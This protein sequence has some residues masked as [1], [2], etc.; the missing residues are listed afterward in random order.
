MLNMDT[1]KKSYASIAALSFI[2][3]TSLPHSPHLHHV[4]LTKFRITYI[5]ACKAA[6]SDPDTLTYDQVL[7]NPY[8]EEWKKGPTKKSHS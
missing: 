4:L 2:E 8:I 7:L 6:L 3:A 1:F 5:Q